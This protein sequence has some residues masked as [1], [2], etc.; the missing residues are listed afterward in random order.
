MSGDRRREWGQLCHLDGGQSPLIR[1]E[2]LTN[3]GT[4]GLNVPTFQTMLPSLVSTFIPTEKVAVPP[5][6]N[7]N[8]DQL[9]SLNMSFKL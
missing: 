8:Q 6:E 2:Q 5:K 7:I 9:I 3:Q 4:L 1:S